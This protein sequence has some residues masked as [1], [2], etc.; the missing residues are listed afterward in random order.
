MLPVMDFVL[1]PHERVQH[2]TLH[3]KACLKM[4]PGVQASGEYL[5]SILPHDKDGSTCQPGDFYWFKVKAK[6]SV[7]KLQG[8]YEKRTGIASR[9]FQASRLLPEAAQMRQLDHFS[10]AIIVFCAT[11]TFDRLNSIQ[12]SLSSSA[13]GSRQPLQPVNSQPRP[14]SIEHTPPV[15][16]KLEPNVNSRPVYTPHDRLNSFQESLSSSTSGSRQLLQPVNPQPRP[17]FIEYTPPAAVKP[18][19]NAN[20]KP[21]HTPQAVVS[22]QSLP[23][24]FR[25]NLPESAKS[26]F[27]LIQEPKPPMSVYQM[28]EESAR[29]HYTAMYHNRLHLIDMDRVIS[30]GY[31]NLSPALRGVYADRAAAD[32]RRYIDE[33]RTHSEQITA[34]SHQKAHQS[35]INAAC[36]PTTHHPAMNTGYLNASQNSTLQAPIQESAPCTSPPPAPKPPQN[37]RIQKLLEDAT[38]EILEEEVKSSDNF[39]E[40]LKGYLTTEGNSTSQDAKHWLQQIS[41]LQSQNVGSPTIIGVV[42]NTGAGKSS[43][44]NAMLDEERLIPTSC[45]R[46]CTAVVTEISWNSNTDPKAKYR[47]EIE[48]IQPADWEKDLRLSL[49]ELLDG[50]GNISRDCTNADSEAG[51]AY[52]KI[53]A[54]YPQKTKD[55]LAKS[56]VEDLMREPGVREVLGTTKHVENALPDMFYKALQSFVDS[57]EKTTGDNKKEKK[58]MEF[59]PLIKVVRIYTKAD[60]LSTGVVVVDLPGVHDSNAARAAVAGSYLKNCTGLWICAPITRAVDDK[61]AKSLLGESFKRQLKYDGTYSRVTFICSKTDDI[62]ITEAMDSLGLEEEMAADWAEID[63]NER[64]QKALKKKIEDMKESRAV[65]GDVMTDAEDALDIW[66]ALKEDLEGGSIVYAPSEVKKSSKRKRSIATTKP[67]KKSKTKDDDLAKTD[68]EDEADSDVESASEA[69]SALEDE[70]QTSQAHGR[71]P[72][73]LEAIDV[74]LEELKTTKKNARRERVQVDAEVK[75]L[76]TELRELKKVQDEVEA[77]MSAI[78]I[79]GRNKYSKGAI[80]QDFAAGIKELDQENAEEADAE[81]FNPEEDLRDYDQVAQ[82]LPVFCC[83]SRAYQKLQGRM[84]RDSAAPGFRTIQ[85]TGIPQLQAHCKKLTEAGRAANCRRY[86]NSLSQLLISLNL[87]ASNNGSGLNLSDAQKA[88]E[89]RFLHNRLQNLE[90]NLEKAVSECLTE[91]KDALSENIFEHFDHVIQLAVDEA[92]ATATKWGA[93]V[94]RFDRSQGGYYWATY[95]AICR[96]DGVYANAQGIHDFNSQLTEPLM[97]HLASHWEKAF[98]RKLPTVLISFTKKSKGLLQTFHQEIEA[99]SQSNGASIVGLKMLAQQLR[100]YEAT[101]T[102][103]STEMVEEINKFQREA[104]REFVPIVAKNLASAYHWCTAESGAGQYARMKQHMSS[105][106]ETHKQQMFN[107]SCQQVK[108]RLTLMCRHVEEAVANKTDEI[109]VLMQR[110]YVT[111]ISGSQIPDGQIM[112]KWERQ[113][114]SAIAIAIEKFENGDSSQEDGGAADEEEAA[115]TSEEISHERVK[116]EVVNEAITSNEAAANGAELQEPDDPNLQLALEAA[117]ASPS[118]DGN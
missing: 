23:P 21:V 27:P 66:E 17:E 11:T 3:R 77:R 4:P 15:A 88:A 2:E 78:C 84:Q 51:I 34:A 54:V 98:A 46:A 44:I 28:F 29:P 37:T 56:S 89:G 106:V 116:E 107:E 85:E 67:K 76:N 72:L 26:S 25:S 71:V 57:K 40:E 16:I 108:Q 61:A 22:S 18:E 68:E 81:N 8:A 47:G 49:N 83:S 33:C 48:F 74:K 117:R 43:I 65:Y 103:L 60:A 69:E 35:P 6:H 24:A 10:D 94:N 13:T 53:K 96:R 7:S 109:F 105:H 99:R 30:D 100:T 91:M 79:E 5:V 59:W 55:D 104:N 113:T 1:N 101:F 38:P 50:S 62:S 36:S 9:L 31:R 52:A 75:K 20:L 73:T 93:P 45:V 12:E 14:E 95:K 82:S 111:V 110:D 90:K 58:Q 70:E 39:L 102:H 92:P 41:T 63:E 97:K 112:P 42:G 19:P 86:L 115:K 118:H 64:Q 87:W 32:N 114:R 80:Q